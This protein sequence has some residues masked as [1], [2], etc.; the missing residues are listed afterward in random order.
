MIRAK[1]VLANDSSTR[2]HRYSME[3]LKIGILPQSGARED[4]GIHT[5]SEEWGHRPGY[6]TVSITVNWGEQVS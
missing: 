3:Y 1:G 4:G 5:G 6:D 2:V